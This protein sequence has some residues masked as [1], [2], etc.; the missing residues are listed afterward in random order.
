MTAVNG[1]SDLLSDLQDSITKEK[2]RLEKDI[3]TAI[4]FIVSRSET[5]FRNLYSEVET[6]TKNQDSSIEK[7]FDKIETLFDDV[8][9]KIERTADQAFHT[10]VTKAESELAKIENASNKALSDIETTSNYLRT[11]AA[12][13]IRSA[14]T[15]ARSDFDEI[16]KIFT[17]EIKKVS[18]D[19]VSRTKLALEEIR[20]DATDDFEKLNAFRRTVDGELSAK[21]KD[22]ENLFTAIKSSAEKELDSISTLVVSETKK[23]EE[24]VKTLKGNIEKAAIY[25]SIASVFVAIAASLII[26]AEKEKRYN[27]EKK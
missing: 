5:D 19:I 6:F 27:N 1:L 25:V 12:Q 4:N 26:V 15:L 16:K 13:E 22:V 14:L 23:V 21:S 20:N 7:R 10:F 17:S 11:K 2:N 24:K 18:D 3:Q 8:G 9:K